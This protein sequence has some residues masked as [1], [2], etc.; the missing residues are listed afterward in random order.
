MLV[1]LL[2]VSR[3]VFRISLVTTASKKNTYDILKWFDI[4]NDFDLILTHDDIF[5]SKPNLEGYIKAMDYFGALPQECLIFEDSD[6]GVT[7][8]AKA[9]VQCCMVTGYG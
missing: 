7:A 2:R 8:A 4:V 6:V 5:R 1:E 3:K 9:G